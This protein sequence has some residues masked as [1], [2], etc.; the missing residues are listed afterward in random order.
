MI[1]ADEQNLSGGHSVRHGD[2][3]ITARGA[4]LLFS[5]FVA[6]D[7]ME[8]PL[9]IEVLVP[10]A[11]L[12][13]VAAGVATVV[14]TRTWRVL[15]APIVLLAVFTMWSALSMLWAREF[16]PSV[17]G[18]KNRVQLLVFV[19]LAWQIVRTRRDV[20]LLMA[21]FVIGCLALVAGTW[22]SFLLGITHAE[23][24][25]GPELDFES[26]R[27]VAAG[28]DPNE[29]GL[30]LALGV[31]MAGY[32]ALTGSGR[33][34]RAWLAYL[35]LGMSALALSGS[36]G[37]NMAAAVSMVLVLLWIRRRSLSAA[38]VVLALL[39]AGGLVAWV[40]TPDTWDRIFTAK[41]QLAGGGTLGERLP[42]WRSGWKVFLANP[43]I[44][45]GLGNFADAVTKPLGHSIVA[46]NTLLSVA[47]ESGVVGFALFYGAILVVFAGASRALRIDRELV[48]G[49]FLTWFIGVFSLTWEHRKTTWL[50]L[51]IGSAFQQLWRR[52]APDALR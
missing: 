4:L 39:I 6:T 47:T 31:P 45:V 15:P 50:L 41:Q 35:P 38:F 5:M 29:M 51:L 37:S 19:V 32:L 27:F 49:L 18:I 23:M 13:L 42:I 17:A 22:R 1:E 16:D 26:A 33:S 48:A 28:F 7:S 43:I 2:V 10:I 34:R 3:G 11:G 20:D 14:R 24:V 30:N 52:R 25:F 36:R 9:G 40:V 12:L 8:M 46:H 21:G 44:G